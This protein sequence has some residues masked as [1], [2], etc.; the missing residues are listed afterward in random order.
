[1]LHSF[2]SRPMYATH[3]THLILCDQKYL[4]N[5]TNYE[6]PLTQYFLVS[7]YFLLGQLFLLTPCPQTSIIQDISTLEMYID[8][9]WNLAKSVYFQHS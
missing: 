6:A 3:P 9:I 4:L 7:S 1:M 5:S 8:M 2:L